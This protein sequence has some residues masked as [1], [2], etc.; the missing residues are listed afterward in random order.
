MLRVAGRAVV[1]KASYR[2]ARVQ[3]PVAPA[4]DMTLM[5]IL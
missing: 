3:P 5:E 4:R 1:G 2:A